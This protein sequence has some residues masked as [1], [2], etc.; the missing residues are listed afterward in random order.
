[1]RPLIKQ[2]YQWL[3][4]ITA[5]TAKQEIIL[6]LV[7]LIAVMMMILP[8]PTL[9]VDI[10]ITV[11]IAFS[12]ILLMVSIYLNDPL[13]LSVFPSLLLITTLYRLS[14]TISTSRLVLLQHD[15][16]NI[17]DAFGHFVVG[18]NLTVGLVIFSIITIVQFIVI[19][20]GTERVAEVGARFSLDGMPGK[21]MSIDGDMRAGV[22]DAA[23]A[24]VLRKQVQQESRFL[25]AMDGAMKFVK[26][27][28]IAGII[29]MLVN[30]IGGVIIAV[31]QYNM[32]F[33]E[34]IETYSIL[35][36]GDGLCGQIPS[37]LISLSAG[38]IVTRIPGE[39]RENLA[40]QL[41][42]QIG[43]QP[44]ALLL[45]SGVLLLFSLLPGFP[46]IDFFI[47]AALA[48]GPVLWLKK[49]QH[50][51]YPQGEERTPE[52][53]T[54][55]ACPLILQLTP[56]IRTEPLP[57]LIS[58]LRWELFEHYGIPLPEVVI[59]TIPA[60]DIVLS[61]T[62]VMRVLIYQEQVFHQPLSDDG[63]PISEQIVSLLQQVLIQHMPEFIG[64]QEARYLM[65]TMEDRYAELVK[66]LQ[67]QLPI[68]KIAEILQRL[69]MERV[70]IRDLRL[71]FGTLIEWAQKEKD[72]LMLTEYVRIAL[73]RHLL[74]RINPERA[75]LPIVRIGERIE[76]L[77]RESIRQ[78]TMGSYAALS[79][80]Q[81]QRI[82]T[83]ISDI[84]QLDP[85]IC[86]VTSMDVRRF[87]RKIVESTL[88]DLAV[89]SW[90]ELGDNY[91]VNVL[92]SLDLS[93]E[94]IDELD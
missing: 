18:G 82:L 47:L 26:G 90:Q 42:G 69:V 17:I 3:Q 50:A 78:T 89:L 33:G 67:R 77:I 9:V 64:V 25:G 72:A 49:R 93:S 15:A 12:V 1:M 20:K 28:A 30:I 24:G 51:A 29:V 83:M 71:I 65:D 54:P 48:A 62:A 14:L 68:S 61:K 34:A 5:G 70:S 46:F 8:L 23:Q 4:Q 21:Q 74:H 73:R 94:E 11:N 59:E 85:A 39:K 19:T 6:A 84:V 16:G 40:G 37:L 10:L 7:L 41:V 57:D 38:I 75:P 32:S 27:D 36:I 80:P 31:M 2:P 43:R 22:I 53:M 88:L 58:A 35:S 13:D 79:Q 87:L 86:L 55:G 92:H 91:P 66:E 45:T 63:T 60:A 52:S 81:Q 44:Q 56:E 76:N